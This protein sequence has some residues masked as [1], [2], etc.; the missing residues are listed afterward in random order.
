MCA[1]S[2]KQR[3]AASAFVVDIWQRRGPGASWWVE[4]QGTVWIMCV[5]VCWG[6]SMTKLRDLMRHA[7][8]QRQKAVPALA[9]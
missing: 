9:Q 4:A 1:Q 5:C 3:G 8:G 7:G 6:E 2:T